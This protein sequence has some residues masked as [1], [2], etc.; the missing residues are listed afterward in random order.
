MRLAVDET[1]CTGCEYCVVKLPQVF[2]MRDG[3]SVPQS[4]EG[5]SEDSVRFVIDNCPA[6]CISIVE[7]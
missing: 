3:I 1:E 7:E 6:E 2:A 5:V 4:I